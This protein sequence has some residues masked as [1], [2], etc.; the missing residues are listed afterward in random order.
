MGK[1]ERGSE[2][3]GQGLRYVMRE[4]EPERKRERRNE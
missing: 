4:I 2:S 1:E 3:F